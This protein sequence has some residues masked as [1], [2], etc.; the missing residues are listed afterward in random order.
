MN[1][2]LTQSSKY[3]LMCA[4]VFLYAANS[5]NAQVIV[6]PGD[7]DELQDLPHVFNMDTDE[8]DWDGFTFW[9]FE[10]AVLERVSNPDPSGINTTDYVLQYEKA[11]GGQAWAGFFWHIAPFQIDDDAVF[12][13]MVWSPFATDIMLKLELQAGPESPEMRQNVPAEEWTLLEWD[14]S[15]LQDAPWD[16]PVLIANLD[17]PADGDVWYFDDFALT[18]AGEPT[19]S[20]PDGNDIPGRISL[21][22]NYPN[23]FNPTTSIA[24]DLPE[25]SHIQLGVYN[26]L[27]QRVALLANDSFSAGSHTVSFDA[28]DL[29]SGTYIYRLQSGDHVLTRSMMLI[30]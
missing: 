8:V 29:S 20:E 12:R 28:T 3:L 25:S 7:D 18:Y 15:G 26:M 23:P 14:L 11:A 9:P 24:F 22:Q 17:D 5:A 13:L 30:K 4:L 10:G 6:E 16:K 27:G 1:K 21:S 19:S 2:L